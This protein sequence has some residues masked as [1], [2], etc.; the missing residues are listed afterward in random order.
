MQLQNKVIVV[1]GA[2]SGIGK[3]LA[4][5]FRAE[6]AERIVSVDLDASGAEATAA[7]VGG[8]AMRADVGVEADVLG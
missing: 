2:A 3:A 7:E 4:V 6:G 1:T 8:V 5:R